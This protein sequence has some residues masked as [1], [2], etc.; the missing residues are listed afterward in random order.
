MPRSRLYHLTGDTG[1]FNR[2][3]IG[4]GPPRKRCGWLRL[5]QVMQ[6]LRLTEHLTGTLTDVYLVN[7]IVLDVTVRLAPGATEAHASVVFIGTH[8]GH[9]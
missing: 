7:L 5:E 2:S 3:S 4:P 8:A 9:P 6:A 1:T